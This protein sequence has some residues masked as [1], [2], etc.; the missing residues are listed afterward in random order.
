MKRLI[1]TYDWQKVI[2][3]N[4]I[5]NVCKQLTNAQLR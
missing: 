4:D 3:E 2:S 5:E 1:N